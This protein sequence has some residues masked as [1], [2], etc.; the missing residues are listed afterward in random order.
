MKDNDQY[1]DCKQGL[2]LTIICAIDLSADYIH[3]FIKNTKKCF[4]E[5]KWEL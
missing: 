3:N 1:S 4:P 5:R 2:Q